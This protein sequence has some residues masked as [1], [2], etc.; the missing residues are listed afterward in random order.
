MKAGLYAIAL[1]AAATLPIGAQKA[2][3]NGW[4]DYGGTLAGQRYS[5]ARQI[6][7]D[8][9]GGLQVAWTFHTHALDKPSTQSNGRSSFEATPVLWNAT[10]Y[11]DTAF[12]AIF[13]LDAATGKLRWSFD[14]QVDRNQGINIVTSRGVS[15]WHAKK[16]KAGICGSDE[17]LMAT[18]DRRLI[19]RDAATGEACPKFG[20]QGS[21]DLEGGIALG[22]RSM[23]GFT[24][25]PTVVND[26]VVLGSS[27]A[28]NL[29]TFAA[30]GAVRGFDAVTG[31]QKWSWDPVRWNSGQHPSTSGSG[32]AW[33]VISAD[34]DNDLIF[35][36][37]GSASNDFYGGTRL[38]DNRD[39]DS[40]VAL[41]ASTG[42]RVWGFQLV[43]HDLWD[44][45]T[46]SEPV[47][48]TFRHR[49]PAVAV[50]TKTSM[51]Y[52]FNRLTGEPLYPVQERKVPVSTLPG[53][54][55]WPTQPFSTLPSLTPLA[56]A[57]EA[58]HLNDAASEKYCR[59]VFSRLEYK[60]IFTPPSSKGSLIYPG[61]VG[62]ANWGSSAF[63]PSTNILYTR[64]S[65]VPYVVRQLRPIRGGLI[66]Q[67][68]QRR[69]LKVLPE[70]LGGDPARL[71]NDLR[72]PDMGG[73]EADDQDPQI[74]TPY[75]LERQGLI[76]P[77]GVPCA[78]T[79]FG[80][81]IA[82]NLDTGQKVWSSPH[83]IMVKS[84]SGS[85]GVGGVIA[86]AG[87][88]VL[89]AS[90]NDAFLRAYNSASGKEIWRGALPVSSNATPMT[91][92][93]QGKQY[94]VIA[95]GGH[96]FLGKGQSDEVVAFALPVPQR[97][98]RKAIELKK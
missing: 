46:P 48:F 4:P 93:V 78:P 80:S 84:G 49:I 23:Y 81:I 82:I 85:I 7:V 76:S 74:G 68:I 10:L 36:P 54:R 64:V 25:P 90:T 8:N 45:D 43:H 96:G 12:N 86:T 61:S 91:Y 50:T 20:N 44:Y 98:S 40:I 83:G 11:F 56:F 47:L 16:P 1:F 66:S 73:I 72:T 30:S 39:A 62:G 29:T 51:V 17:V 69:V 22:D 59:N 3:T 26:M 67:R 9:I 28:D 71:E 35:L 79:P 87:G 14:P 58:L 19:A 38:G 63:D 32:N 18:L 70:S 31:A 77:A 92:V 55:A 88:I 33:S 2:E 57:P 53:E 21:V 37:T 60:G 52:V 95:A 75:R 94:I 42:R 34:V 6:N 41:Q 24:S 13:A 89:G 97:N 15:L 5:T 65:S 27:I